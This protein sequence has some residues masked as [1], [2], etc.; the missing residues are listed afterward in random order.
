MKITSLA[1]LKVFKM[2]TC[3]VT[4]HDNF[5]RNDISNS[6]LLIIEYIVVSLS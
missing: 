6:V 3:D 1:A 2:I 4:S 5:V